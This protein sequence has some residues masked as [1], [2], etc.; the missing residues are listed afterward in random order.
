MTYARVCHFFLIFSAKSLTDTKLFDDSTI[1]LDVF[2]LQVIQHATTLT[3]EGRQ[4]ALCTEVLTVLLQVLGQVVDTEG[5][6][7]NL[8]LGRTGVLG[9]FTVLGKKLSFFLRSQIHDV[10]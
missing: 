2:S 5:E 1:A 4:C 3:D 10:E 6:Q 9:I 7:C 8:A